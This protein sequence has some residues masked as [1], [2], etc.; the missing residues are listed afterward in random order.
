MKKKK[1]YKRVV[2]LLSAMEDHFLWVDV[3]PP[4]FFVPCAL[5]AGKCEGAVLCFAH[6]PAASSSPR[7]GGFSIYFA[8]FYAVE[9][10]VSEERKAVVVPKLPKK[11][12]GHDGD[13]TFRKIQVSEGFWKSLHST[14]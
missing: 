7:R 2:S 1:A 13:Q 14:F 12:S 4:L 10:P 5:W 9:H 3:P 11:P 6:H 8:H